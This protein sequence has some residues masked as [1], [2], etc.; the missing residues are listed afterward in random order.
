MGGPDRERC[1]CDLPGAFRG[2]RVMTPDERNALDDRIEAACADLLSQGIYPSV[3]RLH[4]YPGLGYNPRTIERSRLRLEAA[5]RLGFHIAPPSQG[6]AREPRATSRDAALLREALTLRAEE[7]AESERL[8]SVRLA[9]VRLGPMPWDED[10]DIETDL[11][12]MVAAAL[13]REEDRRRWRITVPE[14]DF[15]RPVEACPCSVQPGRHP[16]YS[17]RERP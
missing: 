5:G 11:T 15:D 17:D 9:A 3:K 4:R 7:I 1:T 8:E 6:P 2:V 12:A 13:R 10:D 16:W 14:P